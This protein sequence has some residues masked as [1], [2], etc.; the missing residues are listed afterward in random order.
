M[1]YFKGESSSLINYDKGNTK[2]LQEISLKVHKEQ[3]LISTHFSSH[4]HS[5]RI[6][7]ENTKGSFLTIPLMRSHYPR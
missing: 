4:P 6:L 5:K 3:T 2:G 1:T 7:R